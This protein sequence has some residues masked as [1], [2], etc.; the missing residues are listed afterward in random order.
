MKE[1]ILIVE[2]Q[3]I[4]AI[5]LERMLGKA[6]YQ[7][8]GI[9]KSVERAL[10]LVAAHK[11]DLVMLDISLKGPLTGIDLAH[12]LREKNIVFIYL[13]ANSN[14]STLDAAKATCPGGFLVKPVRE[15]DVLIMVE[16]ARYKHSLG[17]E[18]MMKVVKGENSPDNSIELN[19]APVVKMS[20]SIAGDH[21]HGI[22][23]KS[24]RLTEVL[25]HLRIVAP[26]ET[27]VLILGE[28]GTGKEKIAQCV[29]D[30]SMRKSGP[31]IKVNCA[32]LPVT[33]IESLLFGHEKG[34]FTG[35]AERRIGKFEQAQ[36]GTIFLDEIGEIPPEVQVKLLRALQEGEIERLGGRETIKLNVRV[37]AATNRNLEKEVAEGR[38]RMDLYYRLNVFP[39]YLPSLRERKEDIPLLVNYFLEQYCRKCG[40]PLMSVAQ[41]L[42]TEMIDYS[43]PGNIRELQHVIERNVLLSTGDTIR[44]L[45]LSSRTTNLSVTPQGETLTVRTIDEN[46]REYILKILKQCSGKITGDDGAAALLKIPPSTL[47]SKIKRLGIKKEHF[48]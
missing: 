33:L 11:P 20:S 48:G 1:K 42:M 36:N 27:G 31:F 30:L 25:H 23:G 46:E 6:G 24:T 19:S 43:W 37:I 5:N 28:S 17:L 3:S 13:S 32:A 21:F 16:I 41:S 44:E 40:K 9:A 45:Q 10:Q 14:Q 22:I 18:P 12:H 15:K 26:T 7:V 39:L 2:D 38:F 8:C 34:A 47:N 35:A 29:H 4:E